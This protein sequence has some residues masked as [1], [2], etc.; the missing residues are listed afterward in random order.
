M[1]L[2]AVYF[3]NKNLKIFNFAHCKDTTH[4]HSFLR[5]SERLSRGEYT[6]SQQSHTDF[7]ESVKDGE[8]TAAPRQQI[9]SVIGKCALLW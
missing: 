8:K 7:S 9:G 3:P 2:W 1:H 5:D 4:I 6:F